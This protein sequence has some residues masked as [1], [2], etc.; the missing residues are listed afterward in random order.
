MPCGPAALKNIKFCFN[1]DFYN[2]ILTGL[3]STLL[4]GEPSHRHGLLVIHFLEVIQESTADA[5]DTFVDAIL[6]KVTWNHTH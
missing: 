3:F 4:N 5:L 2:Y 1:F 6:S